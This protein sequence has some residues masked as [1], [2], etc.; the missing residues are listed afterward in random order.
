MHQVSL[1]YNLITLDEAAQFVIEHAG[2]T[3]LWCFFGPMGAGKT[4]LIKEVCKQ[5]EIKE[6]VSSPTFSL[7]NEYKTIS[8][9]SVYH[10]D[11]FRVHKIEEVYDI[12]YE[13]YF[14][15]GNLCLIEWPEKIEE[16]LKDES[17]IEI[18]I[19]KASE[20]RQLKIS[21]QKSR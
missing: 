16:I 19:S 15:S 1:Q 17:Y 21:H 3:K 12:G 20:G 4:T 11:F 2:N 6:D 9:K 7:V 18:S 5:L 13:D 10:F 8:G 14:Y